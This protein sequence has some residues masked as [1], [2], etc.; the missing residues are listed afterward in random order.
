[1]QKQVNDLGLIAPMIGRILDRIDA[2]DLIVRRLLHKSLQLSNQIVMVCITRAETVESLLKTR[3]I[4]GGS[5]VTHRH[6]L[7]RP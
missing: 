4:D 5:E 2:H 6:T 7:Q 3:F 1:M